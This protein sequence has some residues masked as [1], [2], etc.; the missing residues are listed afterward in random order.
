MKLPAALSDI[1]FRDLCFHA[2]C[3]GVLLGGAVWALA[4]LGEPSAFRVAGT[5]A[6]LL[7]G[8][9]AFVAY[10]MH[11]KKAKPR[12][13]DHVVRW[14]FGVLEGSVTVTIEGLNALVL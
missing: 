14:G 13:T 6:M 5:F 3:C 10:A 8:S 1:S 12:V 7:C 9:L 4:K 2:L 11:L